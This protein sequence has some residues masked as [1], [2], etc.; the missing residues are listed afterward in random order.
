[1][2]SAL[3]AAVL[4]HHPDRGRRWRHVR[5]LQDDTDARIVRSA[6]RRMTE[7]PHDGVRSAA[8]QGGEQLLDPRRVD[9]DLPVLV[10]VAVVLYELLLGAVL[11]RVIGLLCSSAAG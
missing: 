11:L 6:S 7:S 4:L 5:L 1:M 9:Q 2:P 10:L 8:V 3:V